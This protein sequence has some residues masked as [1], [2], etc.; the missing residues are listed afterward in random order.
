MQ[1]E[2]LVLTVR[3]QQDQH[4]KEVRRIVSDA[5][6]DLHLALERQNLPS[7]VVVCSGDGLHDKVVE[8]FTT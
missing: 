4:T 7:T 1:H 5:A 2:D 8:K 6:S 3:C